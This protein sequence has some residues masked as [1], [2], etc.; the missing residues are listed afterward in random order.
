M[1]KQEFERASGR[2]IKTKTT[3]FNSVLL[4]SLRKSKIQLTK[5]KKN[6]N[7]NKVILLSNRLFEHRKKM[8]FLFINEFFENI[9]K[10]VKIHSILSSKDIY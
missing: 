8:N 10:R 1:M 4:K 5:K 3:K 7:H 6:N 9:L 2:E